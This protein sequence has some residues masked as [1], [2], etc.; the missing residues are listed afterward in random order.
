[1]GFMQIIMIVWGACL[2]CFLGLLAYNATITRYE[3][4]QLF[5]NGTNES[6]KQQQSEILHKVQRTAP[7]IRISGSASLLLTLAIAG[8]YTWDAWQ[9]LR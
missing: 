7:F 3:E 6:E 5:L 4:D 2:A 9:R 8:I 1:M